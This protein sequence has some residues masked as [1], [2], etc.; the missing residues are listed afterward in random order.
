MA[1]LFNDP[2][3][4]LFNRTAFASGVALLYIYVRLLRRR[5]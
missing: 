5:S 1:V 4:T 2:L 3:L